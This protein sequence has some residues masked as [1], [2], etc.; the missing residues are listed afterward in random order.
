MSKLEQSVKA[1]T[2]H[3]AANAILPEDID[4]KNAERHI[5]FFKMIDSTTTSIVVV[6]D[7]YKHNYYYYS[8]NLDKAFGFHNKISLMDHNWF[9][10]RF[11]PEDH[12][13]NLAAV[14]ALEFITQQP[15]EERKNYKFT[16]EFRVL[17]DENKYI[18]LIVQNFI[19]EL[20]NN[21]KVWIDMKLFDISPIQDINKPGVAVFSNKITR[22]VIFT[23]EGQKE[24][25]ENISNREKQVLGMIAEGLRSKEIAE[26]LF[27]SVNTVNNHRKNLMDK[28]GV[29]NSSEAVSIAKS[30]GIL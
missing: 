2:A 19:L 16:F 15:I 1:H 20:D 23:M 22:E 25:S 24:S 3:I 8:E 29:S 5:P 27:I 21:G 4:Y 9:R 30:L 28:L 18:R 26:Q 11:H 13:I 12:I 14:K 10:R 6:T 7:Y 17:N